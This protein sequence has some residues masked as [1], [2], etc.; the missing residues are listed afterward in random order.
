MYSKTSINRSC[1]NADNLLRRI[2]TFDPVCFLYTSLSRIYKAIEI[3][4]YSE[5]RKE[6]SSSDGQLLFSPRIKKATCL[7]RKH[8]KIL[9][10][11]EKQKLINWIFLSIF[12]KKKNSHFYILKQKLFLFD[13]TVLKECN[14]F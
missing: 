2:D 12:S 9:G 6:D 13:F 14:T 1:S 4:C 10:I 7:T 3:Y 5:N 8:M 11:S